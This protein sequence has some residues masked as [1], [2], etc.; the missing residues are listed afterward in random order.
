[1]VNSSR[2]RPMVDP[3]RSEGSTNP[4]R[5]EACISLTFFFFVFVT[6]PRLL[7]TS[8]ILQ[9]SKCK[10]LHL[11][12]PLSFLFY[13]CPISSSKFLTISFLSH[14]GHG[15]ELKRKRHLNGTYFDNL[16]RRKA[17]SMEWC[18]ICNVDCEPVEVMT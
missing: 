6:F 14:F 5:V 10:T 1:M 16:R 2:P 12:L 18:W 9:I 3:C 11:P 17:F 15:D 7:H 13:S 4:G 8:L